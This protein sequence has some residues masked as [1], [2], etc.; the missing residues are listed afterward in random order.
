MTDLIKRCVGAQSGAPGI[1]RRL[2]SARVSCCAVLWLAIGLGGA[3]PGLAANSLDWQTS[4][5]RVSADIKLGKLLPLLEQ[6]ASATGWKVF[7]E[8]DT[9]HSVSAKFS[10]LPPGEALRLLL[11]DLSFALVPGTNSSPQLYV[12]R[13][14]MKNA[15]QAVRLSDGKESARKGKLIPNE[16]IVRLKPGAKI[17]DLARTLGAKV[18]G[19][20]DSLN[21]YRLQFQDQAAA[22]TAR[23]QLASN[24]DVASV[25]SN[26]SI[27][28]PPAPAGGQS[29]NLPP[30][31][32]LQLKPPPSNGRIIVGLVD[33]AVQPLG[34][35]LDSFL[36]KAISVAGEAQSDPNNPTNGTSMAETILRSLAAMTKGSSSVQILPVDVYGPSANTTT[37]DVASGIAQA[38]NNGANPI[39][40]SLGSEGDSPF[41]HS[42]IQDASSKNIVF[43]GAAG[44]QPVTTPF[45]PAA[46]PEVM[47]VTAIDQGQI[48]SYANRGSFISLGAPGTSVIYF[49]GQ[50]YYVTGTSASA[51][52]TSGIAA[53]YMDATHNGV[54]QMQAF[55]RSNFGVKIVPAH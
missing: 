49:D 12:F 47:A 45:Y 55:L 1:V 16:L 14:A 21:A 46:Y 6:I 50:P 38:V 27:D 22:D 35:G 3:L 8:P 33:T 25:D 4:Q 53:G 51:A 39:N 36:L 20:I 34:N 28:R 41:L 48:A 2:V 29:S 11:G 42:V 26:F 7:V 40:L 52:F 5:N 18:L 32:Q 17:D 37:F 10:N 54:S 43:I 19:R 44:N 23:E 9:I 24:Q 13:T 30:P 31:P 15:T